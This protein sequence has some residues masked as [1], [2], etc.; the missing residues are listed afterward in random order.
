VELK[1]HLK[2][3]VGNTALESQMKSYRLQF[4]QDQGRLWIQSFEEVKDV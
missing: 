1:G 3:M 4:L 2:I